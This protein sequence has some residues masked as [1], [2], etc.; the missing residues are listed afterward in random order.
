MAGG[1]F[2]VSS[3]GLRLLCRYKFSCGFNLIYKIGQNNKLLDLRR[4]R[5]N[6]YNVTRTRIYKVQQKS[7]F[8]LTNRTSSHRSLFLPSHFAHLNASY[9][10]LTQDSAG[11]C[12]PATRTVR[13]HHQRCPHLNQIF[14]DPTGSLAFT[15]WVGN[16]ILLNCKL[17]NLNT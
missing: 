4:S 8:I 15:L 11:I 5:A 3:T 7:E 13:L 9:Y 6:C 12:K 10:L 14:L 2:W 1:E 17:I 16:T